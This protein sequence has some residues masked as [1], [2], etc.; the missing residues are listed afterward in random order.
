MSM[1][2]TPTKPANETN[3]SLWAEADLTQMLDGFESDAFDSLEKQ[4]GHRTDDW[5]PKPSDRSAVDD[6]LLYLQVH[7][8]LNLDISQARKTFWNERVVETY[9]DERELLNPRE[10]NTLDELRSKKK[11]WIQKINN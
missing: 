8:L 3:P 11:L 6:F 1:I 5:H 10:F 4:F 9:G 7:N 2:N